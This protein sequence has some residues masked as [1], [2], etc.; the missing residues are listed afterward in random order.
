MK[1]LHLTLCHTCSLIGL[2]KMV[3]H[4]PSRLSV[5]G[6]GDGGLVAR[7]NY[8]NI[9]VL[10]PRSWLRLLFVVYTAITGPENRWSWVATVQVAHQHG[11]VCSCYFLHESIIGLWRSSIHRRWERRQLVARE[12]ERLWG[13]EGGGWNGLKEPEGAAIFPWS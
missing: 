13:K 11:F 9:Y 3:T 12:N 7:K 1:E 4:T 2:T 5:R 8:P 10:A 6:G